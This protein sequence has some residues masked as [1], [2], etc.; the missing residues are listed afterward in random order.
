MRC[1]AT[2]RRSSEAMAST[3]CPW[4]IRSSPLRSRPPK[5]TT[6]APDPKKPASAQISDSDDCLSSAESRCTA[7]T[8]TVARSAREK[9]LRSAA[10][11][12]HETD[13]RQSHAP[14]PGAVRLTRRPPATSTMRM[15]S[16]DGARLR[17]PMQ[18]RTGGVDDG[19]VARPLGLACCRF[20]D[21]PSR[22]RRTVRARP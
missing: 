20:R 14:L 3:T 18:V 13:P 12:R 21:S 17:H 11:R 10:N 16:S 22:P 15:S 9:A 19:G 4:P 2:W 5:G 1:G 6:V 8:G 7:T